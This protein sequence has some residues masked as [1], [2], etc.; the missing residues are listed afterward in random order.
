MMVILYLPL[1]ILERKDIMSIRQNGWR[2]IVSPSVLPPSLLSIPIRQTFVNGVF[3]FL[4]HVL[5]SCQLE[6]GIN[7]VDKNIQYN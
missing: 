1:V 7:C 4:P 3:I 5:V 6:K 2:V